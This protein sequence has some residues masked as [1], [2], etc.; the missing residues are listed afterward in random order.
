M[1]IREVL[2]QLD[3]GDKES[4]RSQTCWLLVSLRPP[5]RQPRPCLAAPASRNVAHLL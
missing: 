5:A 1:G 4:S 2:V 3:N